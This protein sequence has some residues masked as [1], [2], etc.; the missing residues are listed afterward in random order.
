MCQ[1][2]NSP[3]QSH[4]FLIITVRRIWSY[5]KTSLHRGSVIDFVLTLT[6]RNKILILSSMATD[7][8]H[9]NLLMISHMIISRLFNVHN[10]SAAICVIQLIIMIVAVFLSQ[11][12]RIKA[13]KD[14]LSLP[15]VMGFSINLHNHNP[16]LF[17]V[18]QRCSC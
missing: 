5:I 1:H 16:S 8:H 4:T 17:I 10:F 9:M 7:Q 12:L 15:S 6:R 14:Y 13:F 18:S 11:R 3:Y 2:T